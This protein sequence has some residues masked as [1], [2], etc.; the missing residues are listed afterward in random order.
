LP[1]TRTQAS[2]RY[3]D[4]LLTWL[5]GF[6]SGDFA[7]GRS[8]VNKDAL[9]GDS[10]TE[11]WIVGH[12]LILAHARAASLYNKEFK[13]SQKGTIGVALSGDFFYPWDPED[14]KDQEAAERRMLFWQGW[15][16]HPM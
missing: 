9:E 11:P 7:P 4:E 5:Q 1:V 10:T 3:E 14:P 8:S 12:A 13:P 6:L 2:F 16:A 15:F